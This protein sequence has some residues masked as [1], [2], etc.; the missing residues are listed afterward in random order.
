MATYKDYQPTNNDDFFTT[1]S[2]WQ[3]ISKIVPKGKVVSMPFYSP[4][5]TP[6]KKL[7]KFVENEIIYQDEDFF[8]HD[9]GDIVIDNP[10]FSI[11]GKII[12]K[13]VERDKP[14]GL[15]LPVSSMC[16]KYMRETMNNSGKRFQ[17]CIFK[18][19]PTY[20]KCSPEGEL[21]DDKKSPAF[22]SIVFCWGLDLEQDITFLE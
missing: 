10:P 6:D 21:R 19:R 11:K 17:I 12:K 2:T 13:L 3:Q 16:Y 15:I 4:Y 9:R 22:D 1:E 5:S 14:F 7:G 18:G 8:E 20:I